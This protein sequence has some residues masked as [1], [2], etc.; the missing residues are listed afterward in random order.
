MYWETEYRRLFYRQLKGVSLDDFYRIVNS[1]SVNP[2][3]V[4]SDEVM[5]NLHIILRYELEKR[6]FDG[7]LQVRDLAKAWNDLSGELL[8]YRPKND[9]EG[10]LQDVHWSIGAFRYF[11]SYALGNMIAAQLWMKLWEDVPNVDE[12]ISSGNFE[13]ILG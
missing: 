5:Y 3:R 4:Q 10:V 12:E 8:G 9:L 6:L 2:V 13:P 1:V 7:S 11:P